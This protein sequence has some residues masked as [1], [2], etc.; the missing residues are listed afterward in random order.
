MDPGHYLPHTSVYCTSNAA[1]PVLAHTALAHS[2]DP[3][4]RHKASPPLYLKDKDK[5][6]Q[7]PATQAPS[8]AVNAW[9]RNKPA[10]PIT[11][12]SP[13]APAPSTER[14]SGVSNP[15]SCITKYFE[16]FDPP[17]LLI[18]ANKLKACQSDDN[19]RLNAMVGH[20]VMINDIYN[21]TKSS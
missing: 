8:K 19:G 16:A 14:N 11:T 13:A 17:E 12:T 15:L 4:T 20:A 21:L 3:S 7:A 1:V 2:P 18:L 6:P 9:F 10:A 5:A